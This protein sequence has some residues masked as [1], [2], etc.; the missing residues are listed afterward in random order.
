MF[1]NIAFIKPQE[2]ISPQFT[3]ENL[4]PMFRKI[5]TVSKVGSARLC[6]CGLG[7]GYYYINGKAVTEDKF[8][9]PAGVTLTYDGSVLKS[10]KTHLIL[11]A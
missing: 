5:F 7:Y 11:E 2:K 9:A 10:G 6:V 1:E 8:T 4:A 3:G